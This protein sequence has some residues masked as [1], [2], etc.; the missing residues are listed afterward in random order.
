MTKDELL[1]Q[2]VNFLET[3]KD[4]NYI[5][6]KEFIKELVN[7]ATSVSY[8]DVFLSQLVTILRNVREYK[9]R[10][11]TIDSHE[12]LKWKNTSLYSLHMQSK[13][14]NVRLLISF[15]DD[16]NPLF[17]SAFYERSGKKKTGY[18]AYTP[19]ANARRNEML[20]RWYYE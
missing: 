18:E 15:D 12:H 20:G 4:C 14:Y 2:L 11:Y 6:H 17:L 1:T 9:H 3:Y 8:Q 13:N 5:F 16:K 10:I 19:T 7:I